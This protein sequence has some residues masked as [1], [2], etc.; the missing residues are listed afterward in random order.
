[1][2]TGHSNPVERKRFQKQ[3]RVIN[4]PL[5]LLEDQQNPKLNHHSMSSEGLAQTHANSG[6][7]FS[8]FVSLLPFLVD[9]VG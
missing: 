9:S 5:P 8:L 7:Y 3:A 6:C 2:K 4:I 1:M